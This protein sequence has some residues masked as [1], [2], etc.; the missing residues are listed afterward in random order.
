MSML[1]VGDMAMAFQL[2]NQNAQL[3]AEMNK[4][5]QEVVT[6]QAADLGKRVTGDF[7]PL[8]AIDRS[9]KMLDSFD[10]T[11]TEA[12]LFTSS[13]QAALGVVH[14]V[15]S[16]VAPLLISSVTNSSYTSQQ[17]VANDA[18]QSLE[19]AISALNT[20]VAGRYAFSGVASDTRPVVNAETMIAEL[21]TATSGATDADSFVTA[22][23]DWFDAPAGGGGYLDVAY[24]GSDQPLA[25]FRVGPDEEARATVTAA[26]EPIRDT[27]KG[28]A[29]A[30]LLAEGV[31]G[32]DMNTRSDI[33]NA[34][35]T[36]IIGADSA[37]IGLRADIGTAESQI[38]EAQTRNAAERAALELSRVDQI[39]VD[40]YDSS[41]ALQALMAQMESLYTLTAR[42]S[43]LNFTDYMR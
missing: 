28:L 20:Q 3:K 8:A 18:R 12:E 9:L 38:A 33:A 21:M 14:E 29:M 36:T 4:L 35:G 5:N 6:G 19:A 41:T 1:S 11:A 31:F 42:V 15:A 7:M 25:G 16:D 26:D 17:A 32:T 10:T 43:R 24:G 39:S 13:A 23:S 30:A 37:L 22:V 34:A 2:R 27:L 40:P